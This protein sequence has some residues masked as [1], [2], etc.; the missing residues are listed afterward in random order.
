VVDAVLLDGFDDKA[1]ALGVKGLG[2]PA[3]FS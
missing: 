3:A 1:N 2:E